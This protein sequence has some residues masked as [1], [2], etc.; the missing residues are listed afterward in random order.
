[1]AYEKRFRITAPKQYA[2]ALAAY[3]DH[4]NVLIKMSVGYIPI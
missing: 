4:V 3:P 1:M 2:N